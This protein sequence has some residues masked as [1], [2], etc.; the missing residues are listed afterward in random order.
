MSNTKTISSLSPIIIQIEE[1]TKKRKEELK[2]NFEKE[3]RE[4]D[5]KMNKEEKDLLK[6]N[7]AQI[8]KEKRA[9]LEKYKE[10]KEFQ[11]K[12]ECLSLKEKLITSAILE[13]KESLKKAPFDVRKKAYEKKINKLEELISFENVFAPLSKKE[14][15]QN[16]LPK[17]KVT[18]KSLG[19]EDGFLVEGEKY[20]FEVSI[21]SI[22][23]ET[24]LNNKS[25]LSL[26]FS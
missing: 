8:E 21:S 17:A 11:L 22:V 10:E 18:E 25:D 14:E 13:I 23:D 7:S 4:L 24:V 5:E 6:K 16:L 3:I 2:K 12:M 20:S 1:E 15:I 9:I 19:I 26:L